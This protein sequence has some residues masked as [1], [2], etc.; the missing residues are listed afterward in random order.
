[1]IE[2][3]QRDGGLVLPIKAFPSAKK[4]KIRGPR[5]GELLVS[6][7]TAPERGKANKA[8]IALLAKQWNLRKSQIALY[9]GETASHKKLLISEIDPVEL[10]RLID[11]TNS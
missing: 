10:R 8:I 5:N 1:M 11:L 4:N 3:E 2:L 9:S 7:T 6:V